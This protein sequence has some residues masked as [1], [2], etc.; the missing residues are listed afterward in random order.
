MEE[1]SPYYL[2]KC[3]YAGEMNV[4]KSSIVHLTIHDNHNSD[5]EPTIG[6][7]FAINKTELEE[8]PLS[9]PSQLP[10]FY[11]NM[12]SEINP[13]KDHCQLVKAHIWDCAGSRRY[14]SILPSYLR[15]VDIA[16]L[17][18]DMSRRDT[19]DELLNWKDDIDKYSKR[20]GFP[21]FVLVGS[22]SDLKP[23]A[24]SQKEIEERAKL[25]NA[26]IYIVS[27]VQSN[28]SSMIKRMMYNSFLKFHE[29]ILKIQYENKEIPE[30]LT[31]KKYKKGNSFVKLNS[32]ESSKSCCFQ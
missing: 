9:N 22:K 3:L 11:H 27:C 26:E 14:R 18:F 32:E 6:L 13:Y 25:W 17:V 20:E 24:V 4:G 8:Y 19:W 15:D 12:K 21:L 7:A 31:I 1:I 28:S 5:S 16:F 23:F 2:I 29:K 10:S 30:H